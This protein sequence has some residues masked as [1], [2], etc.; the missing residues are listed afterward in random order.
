M[1]KR[2]LRYSLVLLT[3]VGC[4]HSALGQSGDGVSKN[5]AVQSLRAF[6]VKVFLEGAHTGSTPAL[7]SAMENAAY[8]PTT[9]P[10]GDAAFAGTPMNYLG[11]EQIS[12]A[13]PAGTI[14]WVLVEIRTNGR[15]R[16]DSST[17]VAALLMEDGTIRAVDGTS[18]PF[19][20]VNVTGS[21]YVVVR[22]RN[23][24]PVMSDGFADFQSSSPVQYDFTT[25]AAQAF[26]TDAMTAV[27]SAWGMLAGDAN[28]ENGISASDLSFWT[29]QNGGPDGYDGGDFN[30]TGAVTASDRAFWAGNNGSSSPVPGN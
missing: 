26:G 27:G 2:F 19:A 8:F 22:H 14:D 25:A 1:T 30:L 6:D 23:H 3:S 9:Q 20:I 18:L 7:A 17:T 11:T 15:T 10:Y 21:H 12:G 28:G 4:L 13:I 16:A 29:G 5:A 24:M